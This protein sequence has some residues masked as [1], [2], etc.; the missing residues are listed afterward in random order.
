[1]AKP[2]GI[3]MI[4]FIGFY[5]FSSLLGPTIAAAVSCREDVKLVLESPRVTNWGTWTSWTYCPSGTAV[6]GMEMRIERP[7]PKND[8]T[9]ANSVKL[10]CS[11]G[12]ILLPHG[13][14]WGNWET[15]VLTNP[16][17]DLKSGSICGHAIGFQVRVEQW[18]DDQDDTSL[19]NI[20]LFCDENSATYDSVSTIIAFDHNN[21]VNSF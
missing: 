9:A 5:Y 10:I 16:N 7:A 3:E 13:G 15:A 20:K 17:R 6:T 1:M 2:F 8:D 21:I 18:A 4:V 12:S 14:Y 11:D 19:N